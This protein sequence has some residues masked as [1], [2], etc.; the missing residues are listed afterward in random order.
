MVGITA[1]MLPLAE[2]KATSHARGVFTFLGGRGLSSVKL[3]VN[4]VGKMNSILSRL[5]AVFA[6]SVS[7]LAVLTLCCFMSTAFRDRSLEIQLG[8]DEGKLHV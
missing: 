1:S 7:V 2:P 5:N 3:S 8:A 4:F 6:F